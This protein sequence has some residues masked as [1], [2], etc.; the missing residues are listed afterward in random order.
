MDVTTERTQLHYALLAQNYARVAVEKLTPA[1]DIDLTDPAVPAQLDQ[2]LRDAT[3]TTNWNAIGH[4][5]AL[6]PHMAGGHFDSLYL[7]ADGH[8]LHLVVVTRFGSSPLQEEWLQT[9]FDYAWPIVENIEGH[10]EKFTLPP[11]L[12]ETGKQLVNAYLGD[13]DPAVQAAA[14]LL[15]AALAAHL[16]NAGPSCALV[17]ICEAGFAP[18]LGS[19]VDQLGGFFRKKFELA[20]YPPYMAAFLWDVNSGEVRGKDEAGGGT[21]SPTQLRQSLKGQ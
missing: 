4:Q 20:V 3:N 12:Q 2:A 1:G 11:A 16:V 6:L 14:S 15:N 10:L 8:V 19:K 18:E 21:L 5:F 17:A 13:D 9:A 7:R